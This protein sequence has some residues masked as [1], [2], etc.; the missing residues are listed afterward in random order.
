MNQ[1]ITAQEIEVAT[2]Y[3]FGYRRNIV[4]TNISWGM[5]LH[6]CDV[7]VMSKAGYL[8]E[9]EIK[10]TKA[11]L[12]KDKLK[13][14]KHDSPK[15]K[16]LY[17]AIPHYLY[18]FKEHIPEKAG[19]FLANLMHVGYSDE[20]QIQLMEARK[21]KEIGDY[22]LSDYEKFDLARLGTMRVWGLKEKLIALQK[23]KPA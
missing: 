4:V 16:C 12:I 5:G 17:F 1:K 15:I 22:C 2:A 19:I 13:Y 21:P 23:N 9:I 14:H 20:M 11:D 8:T 6:E 10:V 3:H 18:E 7:L